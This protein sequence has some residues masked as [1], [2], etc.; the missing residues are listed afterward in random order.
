MSTTDDLYCERSQSSAPFAQP[1][2][3]LRTARQESPV[4]SIIINGMP[5]IDDADVIGKWE[6]YDIVESEENF[7][8]KYPKFPVRTKGH[9]EIYFLPGGQ[10]YWIFEGWTKGVL[11]THAG[12]DYPIINNKYTLQKIENS[13]YMFLE[14]YV[15]DLMI[16]DEKPLINVLKKVSGKIY[17]LSEIGVHDNIDLP[18]VID[19]EVLGLW[20]TIEYIQKISDFDADKPK[21]SFLWLK[22]I[23]FNKDG[24]ALRVYDNEEWHEFWT[25]GYH[26]NMKNK[27]AAAYER[28]IVEGK[29]Y[30]F[31]EWKMGNYVYDGGRLEYYVCERCNTDT[32]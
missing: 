20:K 17:A 24:T 18:F 14:Y 19:E 28:R 3:P 16:T 9:K 15:N 26:L 6:Y 30:L 12:G 21:P 2:L 4:R 27:T 31:I 13:T 11:F 10:K 8:V 29:E 22:S 7:N 25:K 32:V 5:F 23:C 1:T